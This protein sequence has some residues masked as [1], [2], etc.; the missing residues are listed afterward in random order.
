MKQY[1]AEDGIFFKPKTMFCGVK[2]I[3]LKLKAKWDSLYN[4]CYY[5][6]SSKN[7][8]DE[9][10]IPHNGQFVKDEP[11]GK[12]FTISF[13]EWKS[14]RRMWEA[15][16]EKI[17]VSENQPSFEEVEKYFDVSL[18][19]QFRGTSWHFDQFF[20][21]FRFSIRSDRATDLIVSVNKVSCAGDQ[22]LGTIDQVF[23]EYGQLPERAVVIVN[24]AS[25]AQLSNLFQVT[26]KE[27]HWVSTEPTSGQGF[28]TSLNTQWTLMFI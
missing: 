9:L 11:M 12:S 25:P 14:P 5:N 23:E 18:Y 22:Y 7:D 3:E 6:K 24:G 8:L 1:L 28:M 16:T 19:W 4:T 13:E 26:N 21:D 27:R 17:E 15:F 2:E 20:P 10:A